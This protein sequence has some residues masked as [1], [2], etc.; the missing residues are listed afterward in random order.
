MSL[1]VFVFKKC[2][3]LGTVSFL[4][5]HRAMPII[6]YL[7]QFVTECHVFWLFSEVI[8][9][10]PSIQP[11]TIY[12]AHPIRVPQKLEPILADFGYTLSP[13]YH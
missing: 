5:Y 8:G 2:N 11:S 13:I 3:T 6:T 12:F 9:I 1:E 4:L 10:I 7:L